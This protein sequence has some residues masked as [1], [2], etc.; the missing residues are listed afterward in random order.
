MNISKRYGKDKIRID[1]T[2]A[3]H[4]VADIRKDVT[5]AILW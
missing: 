2:V 5:A 1:D 4:R 3:L